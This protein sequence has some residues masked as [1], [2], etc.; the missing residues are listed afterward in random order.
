M[1]IRHDTL[2][3]WNGEPLNGIR[4]PLNI[5]Q[6]WA[7]DE[8]TAVG[9]GKPNLFAAPV[10]KRIVPGSQPTYTLDGQKVVHESYPVEDIPPPS[11]AEL[12]RQ[13]FV[14]EADRQDLV[15]RLRTATPAQIDSWIDNATNAQL[16]NAVKAII[17]R[18]IDFE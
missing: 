12:R 16:K 1:L 17:K 10:G 7:V 14:A 13:A 18:M 2:Q 11:A 8:L 3:R 5:E 6:L 4:H 9:L 15:G